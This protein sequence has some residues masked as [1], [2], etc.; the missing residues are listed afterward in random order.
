MDRVAKDTGTTRV[1]DL[2]APTWTRRRSSPRAMV[3]QSTRAMSAR[4]RLRSSWVLN[5][6]W[7]PST[8]RARRKPMRSESASLITGSSEQ[9]TRT[10]RPLEATN[11]VHWLT[12]NSDGVGGRP[13]PLRAND[14]GPVPS[15]GGP[16][17]PMDG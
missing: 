11:G 2:S 14:R 10:V 1:A 7:A 13:G 6:P 4:E 5:G 8:L 15:G 9:E 3:A 16:E 17:A 12:G